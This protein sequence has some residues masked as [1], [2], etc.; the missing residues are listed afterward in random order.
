MWL[1]I[2]LRAAQPSNSQREMDGIEE[3]KC[4]V[5]QNENFINPFGNLKINIPLKVI[6]VKISS[7]N[8]FISQSDL[9][10]C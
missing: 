6:F 10:F 7:G 8:S 1:P 3:Q 2:N 4:A 9:N 5:R